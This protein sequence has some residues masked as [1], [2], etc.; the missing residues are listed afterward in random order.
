LK[1]FLSFRSFEQLALDLKTEFA[2]KFFKP[3]P[4]APPTPALYAC[5]E[6]SFYN[7][8]RYRNARQ[9][10]A[11]AASSEMSAVKM[12]IVLPMQKKTKFHHF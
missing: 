6:S 3:G 4:A 11:Y 7:C 10:K 12:P 8:I 9:D 2:L 5:D 1:C